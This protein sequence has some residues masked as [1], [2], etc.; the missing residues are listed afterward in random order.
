MSFQQQVRAS[1]TV[2][3]VD[4]TLQVPGCDERRDLPKSPLLHPHLRHRYVWDKL[5]SSNKSVDR[6]ELRELDRCLR[7][8]VIDK[9]WSKYYVR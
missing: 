9:D 3:R 4:G 6:A 1:V 7:R 2:V 8:Q 5:V